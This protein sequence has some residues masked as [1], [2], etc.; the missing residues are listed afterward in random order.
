MKWSIRGALTIALVVLMTSCATSPTTPNANSNTVPPPL[1]GDFNALEPV[2]ES[3]TPFTAQ[4]VR[5]KM[6]TPPPNGHFTWTYA[7]ASSGNFPLRIHFFDERPLIVNR[8]E[9]RTERYPVGRYTIRI[10][11]PLKGP[12]RQPNWDTFEI[13]FDMIPGAE[14]ELVITTNSFSKVTPIMVSLIEDGKEIE[15]RRISSK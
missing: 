4:G 5:E 12:R 6:P 10:A 11:D 8:G 14:I 1:P 3:F 2:D 13:T 15:R 9:H 7:V